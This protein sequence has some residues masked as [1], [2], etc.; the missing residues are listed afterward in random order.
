MP[1]RR[2]CRIM[3]VRIYREN[4]NDPVDLLFTK[5]VLQ[6]KALKFQIHLELRQK[7]RERSNR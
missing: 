1:H 4:R 3:S 2:D 7:Q 6:R 5:G